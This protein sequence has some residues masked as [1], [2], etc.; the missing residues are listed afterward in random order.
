MKWDIYITAVK[1]DKEITDSL[2]DS[3]RNYRLPANTELP[4]PAAD[5]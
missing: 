3:L 2:A 1:E 4:D 5:F